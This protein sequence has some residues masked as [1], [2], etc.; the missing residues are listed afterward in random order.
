MLIQVLEVVLA[1]VLE[2]V[3]EV[4]LEVISANFTIIVSFFLEW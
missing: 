4:A 2:V 1:V 3:L